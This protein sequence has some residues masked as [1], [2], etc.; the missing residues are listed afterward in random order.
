MQQ[1]LLNCR[2]YQLIL[3]KNWKLCNGYWYI[4]VWKKWEWARADS[5]RDAGGT[6]A[7]L[8]NLQAY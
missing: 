6:I 1:I 7:V 4:Q 2:K 8:C 5:L 3:D